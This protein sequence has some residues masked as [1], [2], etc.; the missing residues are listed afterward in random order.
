MWYNYP[1]IDIILSSSVIE[2][3]KDSIGLHDYLTTLGKY[4]NLRFQVIPE[5]FALSIN[6]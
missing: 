3:M 5:I 2:N 1:F 6:K 4:S